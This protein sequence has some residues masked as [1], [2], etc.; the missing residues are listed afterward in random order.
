[1]RG[2]TLS[3]RKTSKDQVSHSPD[4]S[5][6]EPKPKEEKLRIQLFNCLSIVNIFTCSRN[7]LRLND[8]H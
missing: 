6:K 2:L 1:M 4:T 8:H 3:K 5:G 7:V